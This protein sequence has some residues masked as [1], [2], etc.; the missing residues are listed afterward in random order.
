VRSFLLGTLP[1]VALSL[2]DCSGAGG[3]NQDFGVV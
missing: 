3:S 1:A 2:V